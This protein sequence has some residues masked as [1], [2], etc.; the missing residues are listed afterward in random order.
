MKVFVKSHLCS[1]R[2]GYLC[3][4][5]AYSI[6]R[7]V[8][9]IQNIIGHTLLTYGFFGLG[10]LLITASFLLDRDAFKNTRLILPAAFLVSLSQPTLCLWRA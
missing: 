8:L 5:T 6:L 2:Y 3:M 1:F 10:I 4:L 7:E 9:A